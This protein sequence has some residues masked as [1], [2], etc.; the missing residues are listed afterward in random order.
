MR[1]ASTKVRGRASAVCDGVVSHAEPRLV[2]FSVL[3]STGYLNNKHTF[4]R[5]FETTQMVTDCLAP[6]ALD[7]GGVGWKSCIRVRLLH[8]KVRQRLR[9]LKSWDADR[10]GV[11]INQEDLCA[12]QLSFCFNVLLGLR[13]MGVPVTR[14]ECEDYTHTWRYMGH[15]LGVIPEMNPCTSFFNSQALMESIFMHLVKPDETSIRLAH[16]A[17]QSISGKPPAFLPFGANAQ[18]SRMMLGD[19]MADLLQLPP[20]NLCYL[21]M[22]R[23]GF[24]VFVRC[25]A[26]LTRLPVIGPALMVASLSSMRR[27]VELGLGGHRTSFLMSHEPKSVKTGLEDPVVSTTDHIGPPMTRELKMAVWLRRIAMWLVGVIVAARFG[28]AAW[29]WVFSLYSFR[30]FRRRVLMG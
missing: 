23:L 10:W 18:M 1:P 15:L 28:L 27:F 21:I 6:G 7:V 5:L 9:R 11:P 25:R 19:N 12:T 14:Q 30:R 26:L 20:N 29:K 8:A 24:F 17:L 2:V 3:T 4:R 13:H 16:N 22:H